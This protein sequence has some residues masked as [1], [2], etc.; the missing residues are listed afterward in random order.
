MN[1]R[2]GTLADDQVNAKILHRGVENFFEGRL[3]AMNFVEKEKI[4]QIKRS[5]DGGEI[6]FFFEQRARADLD[7]RAHFVGENLRERGLAQSGRAIKQHMVERIA[8]IAR[9]VHGNFQIFFHARLAD[10]VFDLLR[11]NGCV[12]AR[13]FLER[14]A[15]NDSAAIFGHSSRPAR[16]DFCIAELPR[17]WSDERSSFSKSLPLDARDFS[18]ACSTDFVS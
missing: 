10:E 12:K 15:G 2:A 3:Q 4:A 5:E 11:T 17:I 8:A 7:G 16:A 6:T 18:T 13:V 9:G 14:F 1:P